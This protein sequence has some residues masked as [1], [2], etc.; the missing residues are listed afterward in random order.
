ML[1]LVRQYGEERLE[2]ACKRAVYFHAF[3]RRS[4]LSILKSNLDKEPLPTEES[5]PKKSSSHENIRGPYYFS[6]T[7]QE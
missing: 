1:N 2:S 7:N 4:V 6:P 3:T 5:P